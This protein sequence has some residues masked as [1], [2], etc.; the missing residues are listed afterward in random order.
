M[1]RMIERN[2][3]DLQKIIDKCENP[4]KPQFTNEEYG[5]ITC[6]IHNYIKALKYRR[7]RIDTHREAYNLKAS[8]FYARKQTM[9]IAERLNEIAKDL[10]EPT[11]TDQLEIFLKEEEKRLT[12]KLV[13]HNEKIVEIT[14]HLQ[15]LEEK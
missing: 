12:K 6:A 10:K 11:I 9:I 3:V 13:K 2:I 1:G 15:E 4:N 14:S 5:L 8:L 7:Q